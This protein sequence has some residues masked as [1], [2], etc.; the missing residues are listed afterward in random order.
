MR[1]CR[2]WR[3][4]FLGLWI[5]GQCLS[6][7]LARETLERGLTTVKF[8]QDIIDL[9]RSKRY[10]SRAALDIGAGRGETTAAL[11]VNFAVV[12][13]ID[14]YWDLSDELGC[15]HLESGRL[16]KRDGTRINNIVR[17]HM[18]TGLPYA[19][20]TLADQNFSVAVIDAQ[21]KFESVVRETFHV[22]RDLPCCVET[23]IYH[24]FC[25]EEVFQAILWFELAGIL[26]FQKFMG[27]S[28]D[29][30]FCRSVG[31][32]LDRAEGVAVKVVR[33]PLQDFRQRVEE[34]FQA[35]LP[36]KGAMHQRLNGSQWLLLS[37]TPTIGV[38][39]IRLWPQLSY[40]SV[41]ERPRLNL[42][43]FPR[44]PGR[45]GGTKLYL[46]LAELVTKNKPAVAF[47]NPGRARWL[48]AGFLDR[49]F[50]L[51]RMPLPQ[52][53][54]LRKEFPVDGFMCINLRWSIGLAKDLDHL[55]HV[56]NSLAD[57]IARR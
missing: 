46:G 30:P 2:A 43:R 49:E 20:S 38:M 37:D 32:N 22:L 7:E 26:T 18:D 52:G 17:L 16:L 40:I 47:I 21:H 24:D 13:A 3:S 4:G 55:L 34:L 11:A 1:G 14:K 27:E 10:A 19:F 12:V 42:R 8:K 28:F 44:V 39:T 56:D 9:F 50:Q 41:L 36:G 53:H 6:A 48:L 57:R 51:I 23:I 31:E 33:R 54:P 29:S 5:C 45:L 15:C 35:F 25:F